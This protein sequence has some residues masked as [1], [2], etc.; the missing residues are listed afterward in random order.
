M[1]TTCDGCSGNGGWFLATNGEQHLSDP[2]NEFGEHSWQRCPDCLGTGKE[3]EKSMPNCKLCGEPMPQGEEMFNYHGYSSPCP[4]PPL[5][6]TGSSMIQAMGDKVIVI[7]D[8][9]E[10]KIGSI[11]LPDVAKQAT[12]TGRV[13]AV[14]PEVQGVKEGDRVL[15]GKYD[16]RVFKLNYDQE[17]LALTQDNILALVMEG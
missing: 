2:Y 3:G 4:K 8:E 9:E 5:R 13:I 12:N 17:Y 7:R 15:F 6:E 10:E 1:R 11:I 16:G 14:G